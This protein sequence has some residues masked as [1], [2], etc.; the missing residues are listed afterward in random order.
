[1]KT[2][3]SYGQYSILPNGIVPKRRALFDAWPSHAA[4]PPT[5]GIIN[6]LSGNYAVY[7]ATL[8]KD[9]NAYFW[10]SAC[11][12][13]HD[14]ASAFD[15]SVVNW[16]VTGYPGNWFGEGF[17]AVMRPRLITKILQSQLSVW[18]AAN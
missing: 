6:G 17:N 2:L 9:G 15:A 12:M 11:D 3:N 10:I 4:F 1:M 8:L 7:L 13:S 14:V 18:Q 5:H 16:Q